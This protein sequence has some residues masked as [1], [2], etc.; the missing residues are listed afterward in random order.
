MCFSCERIKRIEGEY[1]SSTGTL[2]IISHAETFANTVLEV[3]EKKYGNIKEI[4]EERRKKLD[5]ILNIIALAAFVSAIKDGSD[6]YLTLKQNFAFFV[7]PSSLLNFDAFMS[8]IASLAVISLAGYIIFKYKEY[9]DPEKKNKHP[10]L[11]SIC[12]SFLV[13]IALVY[14]AIKS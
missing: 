6:L 4:E 11:I 13:T 1:L 10:V 7:F 3:I 8:L 2:D 9:K 5:G 14:W 12:F